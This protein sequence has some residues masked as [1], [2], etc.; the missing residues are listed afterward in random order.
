MEQLSP[1][2]IAKFI[3]ERDESK[4]W[5][6]QTLDDIS[7]SDWHRLS[8]TPEHTIELDIQKF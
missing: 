3:A 8:S 4:I 6:G 1:F 7:V 5:K 2:E